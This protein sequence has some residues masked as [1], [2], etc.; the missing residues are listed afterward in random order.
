MVLLKK[1]SQPLT[2]DLNSDAMEIDTFQTSESLTNAA[3]IDVSHMEIDAPDNNP[4]PMW[5]EPASGQLGVFSL[6]VSTRAGSTRF[7][8]CTYG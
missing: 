4:S 1:N 2:T 6:R 8:E 5:Q 7:C 3:Q